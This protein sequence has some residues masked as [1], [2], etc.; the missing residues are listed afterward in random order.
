MAT[1]RVW[2]A[3]QALWTLPVSVTAGS[4]DWVTDPDFGYEI[5]ASCPGI[6]D[7]ELLQPSLLYARQGRE[8]EYA[9][10]VSQLKTAR[11][12]YLAGFA[13]LDPRVARAAEG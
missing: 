13:D 7:V 12:A 2:Q 3:T 10:V 1:Q 4:I 8:A 5:A 11:R 6:D 9:D